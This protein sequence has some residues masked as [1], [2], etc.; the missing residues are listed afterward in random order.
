MEPDPA[1]VRRALNDLLVR[2]SPPLVLAINPLV[3][4]LLAPPLWRTA[5]LGPVLIVA[6]LLGLVNLVVHGVYRRYRREPGPDARA[7]RW[8]DRF[9]VVSL[10]NSAVWGLG[11]LWVFALAPEPERYLVAAVILGVGAGTLVR[12]AASF[13]QVAGFVLLAIPP[14]ALHGLVEGTAIGVTYGVGMLVYVGAMLSFAKVNIDAHVRAARLH[15]AHQ[16]NRDALRRTEATLEVA[17]A[18]LSQADRMA[19]LGRL[20]AG[21]AHEINTPV[22]NAMTAVSLLECQAREALADLEAGGLTRGRLDQVLHH[23]AEAGM[24]AES[25][26]RR[27]VDLIQGFKD[28]AADRAS[29]Q[30]RT[31]NLAAYL[32]EIM[33][34]LRPRVRAAPHSVGL[35]SD[36]DLVL[37]SYPGALSQVVTNLVVNALTHAFPPEGPAGTVTVT[38]RADGPDHVLLTVADDGRG[39]DPSVRDR[40]FEPFVTTNRAGGGTGLGMGLA[41]A[42]VTQ[43]L[44]GTLS[45]DSAPGAGTRIEVRLPR[46][47]PQ[48]AEGEGA[49][50]AASPL[51]VSPRRT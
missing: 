50:A 32:A 18:H 8:R 19:S 44:G 40:L 7:F 2:G 21:M 4:A 38:A 41:L 11:G 16:S 23:C 43:V 5:A 31:I 45:V 30:R 29:A 25:N 49:D 35:G 22:G 12:E 6:T 46:V 15:F 47:A 13:R 48:P 37:D 26:L 20:M 36:P 39:I 24:L 27:A 10:A 51:S 9:F 1:A 34:S 3:A 14:I 33:I 17:Q 42:Q 28:V